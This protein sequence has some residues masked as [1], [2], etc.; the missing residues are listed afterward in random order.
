MRDLEGQLI[1]FWNDANGPPECRYLWP[2]L[3]QHPWNQRGSYQKQRIPG[4]APDLMDQNLYSN[5]IL[6]SFICMV[7]FEIH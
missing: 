7:K 2:V 4:P 1:T 6:C 3:N 5:E